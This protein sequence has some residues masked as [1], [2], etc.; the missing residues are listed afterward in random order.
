MYDIR[1]SV[2][3]IYANFTS[4]KC[5][6]MSKY[7]PTYASRNHLN[8]IIFPKNFVER[9]EFN[10]VSVFDI[11]GQ[12]IYW[13]NRRM[14]T[15]S[16]I[17]HQRQRSFDCPRGYWTPQVEKLI[18]L[19]PYALKIPLNRWNLK[20][21]FIRQVFGNSPNSLFPNAIITFCW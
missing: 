21:R 3:K 17:Y 20:D 13:F 12:S 19:S 18:S 7:P 1:S 16:Q 14:W 4:R 10:C 6:N 15:S 5:Q 8:Y 9:S 2:F 11:C